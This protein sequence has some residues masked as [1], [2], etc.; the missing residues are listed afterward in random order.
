MAAS[1]VTRALPVPRKLGELVDHLREV[2]VTHHEDAV[3]PM[4]D[5]AM[6]DDGTIRVPGRG[7]HLLNDWSRAQLATVLGLRW[8]RWFAEASNIERAEEV[9]RRLHRARG[10]V[11]V[12]TGLGSDGP[13]IRAVVSPSYQA[14]PDSTI[15]ASLLR[16]LGDLRVTRY[17]VTDMTTSWVVEVGEPLKKGGI[18]GTLHGGLLVRNSDVGYASLAVVAHL[19]RLVCSNGMTA[20]VPSAEILR[21]RHRHLD[22]GRVEERLVEG[23]A[24]LPASLRRAG[25]VVAASTERRVDGIEAEIRGVLREAHL[26]R[27]HER[28][29]G[30][31]YEREPHASAF[32][33]AQAMT[34]AAQEFPPEQ[35]IELEHVAG[36][37]LGRGP[38]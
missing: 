8:D 13:V 19:I 26:L 14:V 23:A 28:A 36:Q 2:E 37:Y 11:R 5:L 10:H 21:V 20:P 29:V 7:D 6:G 12:R 17:T 3:V 34:L 25:E 16:V 18:V 33:V 4:A 38:A 15:A 35:R 32:G 27:R 30:A 24:R 31:A 22:L 1:W 9:N